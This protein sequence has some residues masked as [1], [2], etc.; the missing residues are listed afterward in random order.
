MSSVH[1]NHITHESEW[2]QRDIENYNWHQLR[3]NNQRASNDGTLLVS[4]FIFAIPW[5]NFDLVVPLSFVHALETMK[6]KTSR[7]KAERKKCSSEWYREI[8]RVWLKS[9]HQNIS[10]R[11]QTFIQHHWHGHIQTTI[12]HTH[13]NVHAHVHNS[14]GTAN[15]SECFIDSILT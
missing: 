4:G 8:E 1:E 12:L 5:V 9:G 14:S 2:R 6:K 3:I 7:K 11:L 10:I 15:I 13:Q